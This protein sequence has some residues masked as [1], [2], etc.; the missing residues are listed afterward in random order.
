MRENPSETIEQLEA[1]L[2]ARK[3]QSS[4]WEADPIFSEYFGQPV[5]FITYIGIKDLSKIKIKP[6]LLRGVD[7]KRERIQIAKLYILFAFPKEKMPDVKPYIKI[8]PSVK[9]QNLQPPED[10]NERF[11]IDDKLLQQAQKDKSNVTLVTRTGH[12][13]NGCILHFEKYILY[14]Q[15][16]GQL[17]V[18]YRHGLFE[19][20]ISEQEN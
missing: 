9:V 2:Q 8:R 20:T 3:E 17:V 1:L 13:L 4:D 12:V 16:G 15:I 6:Y 19:F 14:M 10:P 18:V 7:P 11:H 5:R